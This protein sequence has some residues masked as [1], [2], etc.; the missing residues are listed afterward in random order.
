MRPA[1]FVLGFAAMAAYAQAPAP[2]QRLSVSWQA[3]WTLR[4]R[5]APEQTPALGATATPGWRVSTGQAEL[6]P[7]FDG[8]RLLLVHAVPKKLQALDPAT[9]RPFWNAP[10]TGL[11]DGPPQLAGDTILCPLEGGRIALLDPASGAMR[12]LIQMPPWQPAADETAPSRPRMLFPLKAGSTLVAGWA[13]PSG[14]PRPEL[15]LFGF[16][17]ESGA[18][19]WSV[20]LPLGSEVHPLAH[21]NLVL[22]AGGGQVTAFRLTDGVQAWSTRLTRRATFESGQVISGRLLLRTSQEVVAL[23]ATTGQLLWTQP[24]SDTSLLLGTGDLLVL[25]ATKGTFNPETFVMTLDARSGRLV[26]EREVVSARL[27]WV[28]P[29]MVLV[30]DGDDLLSLDLITGRERWRKALGGALLAPLQ[31]QGN[32]ILALHRAKSQPR[33]SGFR[34]DDGGETFLLPVQDK[35]APGG[36]LAGP[37]GLYL[38]LADGGL[39]GYR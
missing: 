18:P 22:T 36:F 24:L 34:L 39:A 9:G 27:P 10:F 33:I 14:E 21:G 38:P 7:T 15:A 28:L 4:S 19:R 35:L 25:L 17:M 3:Q 29:R 23:D 37:Q 30:N 13:S 31:L 8:T 20:A 6:A 12:H 32:R 26:W 16:D 11:L 1:P 2:L 5:W